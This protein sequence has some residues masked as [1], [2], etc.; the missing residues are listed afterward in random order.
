MNKYE[1]FDKLFLQLPS[2]E[3]GQKVKGSFSLNHFIKVI[4]IDTNCSCVQASVNG[5]TLDFTITTKDKKPLKGQQLAKGYTA[6]ITVT[7]TVNTVRQ[8]DKLQVSF[9]FKN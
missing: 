8:Y 3:R 2:V 6:T 1:V 7:Y 4:S 9:E 5:A